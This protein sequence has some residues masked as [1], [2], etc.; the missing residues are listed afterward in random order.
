MKMRSRIVLGYLF[1]K[2][3]LQ[4]LNYRFHIEIFSTSRDC[5]YIQHKII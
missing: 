2:D 3:N 5:A 4:T 1:T